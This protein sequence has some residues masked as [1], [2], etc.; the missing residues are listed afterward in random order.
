MKLFRLL[1]ALSFVFLAHQ[2][3]EYGYDYRGNYV[4]KK[5]GNKK[6]EY[7]YDYRGN[8]VPKKIEYGYD[9][10]GNYVPKKKKE[11]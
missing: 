9:Y 5:I 10:R 3:L 8:Y 11:K 2:T 4:P 7:G 1:I 6:I